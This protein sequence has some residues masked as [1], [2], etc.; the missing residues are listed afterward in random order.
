MSTEQQLEAW[1]TVMTPAFIS[2]AVI[3]VSGV[4]AIVVDDLRHSR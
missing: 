2:L 4:V 3:A 1:A